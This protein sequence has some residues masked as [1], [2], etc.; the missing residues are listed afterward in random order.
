[1][2]E[3]SITLKLDPREWDLVREA[4][5]FAHGNDQYVAKDSSTDVKLRNK[6]RARAVE[7]DAIM[8]KLS[9]G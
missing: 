3:A 4:I 5:L 7:Y 1:M 6:A 8:R 2:A 9:I